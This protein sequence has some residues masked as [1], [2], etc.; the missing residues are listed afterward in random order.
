MD[1]SQPTNGISM[2]WILPCTLEPWSSRHQR[3]DRFRKSQ[4]N[5]FETDDCPEDAFVSQL[6]SKIPR[7]TCVMWLYGW[8]DAKTLKVR[9]DLGDRIRPLMT[10]S[11]RC[12]TTSTYIDH[13]NIMYPSTSII[14][15]SLDESWSNKMNIEESRCQVINFD[16]FVE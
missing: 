9:R 8:V 16:E 6:F 15:P 10:I 2:M 12:K 7:L 3:L 11:L 1:S 5:R 14:Y 13:S 4:G